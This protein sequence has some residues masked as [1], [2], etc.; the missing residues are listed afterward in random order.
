MR[1]KII[2][3]FIVAFTVIATLSG[4]Q[5]ASAAV[6]NTGHSEA[7]IKFTVKEKPSVTIPVIKDN[8]DTGGGTLPQ[9]GEKQN[10]MR[11]MLACFLI[12]L[13]VQVYR[14]GRRMAE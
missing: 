13:G 11:L 10:N 1:A 2:V 9:T 8:D 12:F 7:G 6:E 4:S 14:N 3:G 5:N